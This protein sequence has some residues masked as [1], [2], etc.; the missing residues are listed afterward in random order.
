[1]NTLNLDRIHRLGA[2]TLATAALTTTGCVSG[3]NE[4]RFKDTR[5]MSAPYL[6]TMGLDVQTVNGSIEVRRAA[7]D[8][9]EILAEIRAQTQERLDNTFIVANQV[10]D[11]LVVR[12]EWAEGK[13]LNNEG[14][15]FNIAMPA[16]ESLTLTSSNGRITVESLSGD[17]DLNTSNG[18]ITVTDHVGD[19]YASTSNGRITL[20]SIDGEI[21]ADTSNG[22]VRVIAASGPVEVDTSNGSVVIELTNDNAGPV[23]AETSNGSVVLAVGDAFEG[24]VNADT[25]NGSVHCEMNNITAHKISKDHWRFIFSEADSRSRIDTNNGSITIKRRGDV[26]ASAED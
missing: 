23:S 20:E 15:A 24:T 18:R 12:V 9:I 11:D 16:T 17:A 13:R 26:S 7:S 5:A 4:A 3:W 2:L 1:M 10:G 14:C 19:I 21:H 25:N 8:T 6:G 22:R